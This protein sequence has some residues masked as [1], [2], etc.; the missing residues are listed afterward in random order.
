MGNLFLKLLNMSITAGWFIL[1]VICIRLLFRKIPKWIICLLWGAA[2]VRLICPFS[3]ESRL[4]ILSNAEPIKSTTIMEGEVQKYIPSIDSHLTV[5]KNTINPMLAETFAYHEWESAAPFQVIIYIAGILWAC[6]VVLLMLYAL[7][8]TIK[9]HR[10]VNESV[11][12]RDPIFICDAV[13][14]S[15]ILGIFKPRIYLSSALCGNEINYIIAH[16]STHLKRKDHWWKLLGY[17][18]LCVYWF[19]P[20]CHVAYALFCKDIE[21]ACDEKTVKNMSFHEKKEYSKVLLSC[22]DRKNRIMAYPLAFGGTGIKER[23]KSVLHYKKPSLWIL[24]ASAAVCITLTVCFLTN[25][26]PAGQP[27]A[28]PSFG[29]A[30]SGIK[31]D[32]LKKTVPATQNSVSENNALSRSE[33]SPAEKDSASD[34]LLYEQ[35][36]ADKVCIEVQP[37]IIREKLSYFYIPEGED[38]K[39]LSEQVKAL[40]LNW[41]PSGKNPLWE[42][43]REAGWQIFYQNTVM[44]AFEDG[45]L[46]AY[47]DDETGIG[48]AFLEVP[49]LCGYIQ[50]MLAEKI[51][52]QSYDISNIKDIVSARLDVNSI[53]TGWKFYSQTITDKETLQKFEE[54]FRNAQYI[55]GGADCGNECA[56]L[57][58]TLADGNAVRLSMATDSCSNF[59]INGVA[60]DYRPVPDWDNSEFFKCFHEIPW[61]FDVEIQ[62]SDAGAGAKRARHNSSLLDAHILKSGDDT[63]NIPDS[64]VIFITENDIMKGNQPIYPVERYVTI[65]KSKVLFGDGSHILYV[66]GQYRGNDEIGKLMHDFSCTDPTDMNYE[67]LAKRARYFKNN[68]KGVTAMSKILEEMRNEAAKEAELKIA[69]ETAERMIKKGKMTLEEIAECVPILSLNELKEIEISVMHLV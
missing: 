46:Y 34:S 22:A 67:A 16:E 27:A 58:L 41:K 19:H 11:C 43:H 64:Y 49:E 31:N 26:I 48:E 9:L 37:S 20:L 54:W 63:E 28:T 33:K 17:L 29:I 36:K 44:T 23:V 18:L 55:F 42:G 1:A 7:C 66:N 38:Q 68:E 35:P 65:G 13:N 6:G 30:A 10:L 61:E 2:A 47:S 62:R 51:N 32:L 60:Y 50:T 69:K 40:D 57:E 8:N 5:V 21:L 3:I 59:S 52:Y 39:W 56:C 12:V 53:S 25:P 4:S 14:S 45:Y 15:F 24:A